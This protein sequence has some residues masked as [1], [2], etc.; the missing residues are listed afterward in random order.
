MIGTSHSVAK[1]LGRKLGTKNIAIVV[2]HVLGKVLW[3]HVLAN[4]SNHLG[5]Q[6]LL[7]KIDRVV[8]RLKQR[9]RVAKDHNE[10]S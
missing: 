8:P 7:H 1:L 6:H 9:L 3:L 10:L 4:G 2:L 5:S